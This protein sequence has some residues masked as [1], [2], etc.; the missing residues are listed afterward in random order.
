MAP[1]KESG[2]T[3][4]KTSAGRG[5]SKRAGRTAEET[6]GRARNVTMVDID[7]WSSF[8]EMF[9]GQAEGE[10]AERHDGGQ[11]P[12]KGTRTVGTKPGRRRRSPQAA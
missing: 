2:R 10:S 1:E 7:P 3:R 11:E 9:W 5:D 4:R 6:V 8:F 12:A